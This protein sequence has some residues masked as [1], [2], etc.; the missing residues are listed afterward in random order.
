MGLAQQQVRQEVELAGTAGDGQ[1]AV[2]VPLGVGEALQERLGQP[3]V[4]VENSV[5]KS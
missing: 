5:L 2:G 4:G 1:S 3:G